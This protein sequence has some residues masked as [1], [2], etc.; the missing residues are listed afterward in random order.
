[1]L[2]KT[3]CAGWEKL[4]QRTSQRAGEGGVGRVRV[5]LV[6][7]TPPSPCGSPAPVTLVVGQS[8]RHSPQ[9]PPTPSRQ[10]GE[11][12]GGFGLSLLGHQA[13]GPQ[14]CPGLQS[15]TPVC[16]VLGELEGPKVRAGLLWL[17]WFPD[18]EACGAR[19]PAPLK[20]SPSSFPT[21]CGNWG[22]QV[23]WEE[24]S[25]LGGVTG[26]AD[27]RGGHQ[28]FLGACHQ[29]KLNR[30]DTGALGGPGLSLRSLPFAGVTQAEPEAPPP[31]THGS[32]VAPKAK[33]GQRVVA[34]REGV[35]VRRWGLRN[36]S[37]PSRLSVPSGPS[38]VRAKQACS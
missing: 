10:M 6:T 28:C 5:T 4:G 34:N 13:A 12:A 32:G 15:L 25:M 33:E 18:Q 3:V 38:L 30:F 20:G 36:F 31:P 19:A 9:P 2:R 22:W 11:G 17:W 8:L 23:S 1:M 27:V 24:G 14:L 26:E 21:V 29:H 16:P 35:G 37:P 7:S